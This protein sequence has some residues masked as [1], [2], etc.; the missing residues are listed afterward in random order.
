MSECRASANTNRLLLAVLDEYEDWGTTQMKHVKETPAEMLPP[1][2]S[3]RLTFEYVLT[4]LQVRK[5]S[6]ISRFC[7]YSWQFSPSKVFHYTVLGFEYVLTF[8]K[9]PSYLSM[10]TDVCLAIGTIWESLEVNLRIVFI[11]CCQAHQPLV[12]RTADVWICVDLTR[13]V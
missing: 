3:N 10:V 8:L 7:G 1:T 5:L 13:Q 6:R 4:F 9:L 11:L 12:M 2:L